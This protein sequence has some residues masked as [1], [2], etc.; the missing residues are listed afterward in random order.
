MNQ[1]VIQPYDIMHLTDVKVQ[2]TVC[3]CTHLVCTYIQA[4]SSIKR[5][6]P[7]VSATKLEEITCLSTNALHTSHNVISRINCG[8]WLHSVLCQQLTSRS[9][10]QSTTHLCTIQVC[11]VGN[12]SREKVTS[13]YHTTKVQLLRISHTTLHSTQ[14][15][16]IKGGNP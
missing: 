2:S 10:I 4:V 8:Q 7:K 6:G 13:V 1:I 11:N 16:T 3:V 14:R 9:K 12:V 5:K 15:K